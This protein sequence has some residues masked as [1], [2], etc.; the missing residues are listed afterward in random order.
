MWV[1]LIWS[2]ASDS[3]NKMDLNISILHSFYK[4]G[5]GGGGVPV[6]FRG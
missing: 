6:E 1:D 5:R 4:K 3:K 2:P